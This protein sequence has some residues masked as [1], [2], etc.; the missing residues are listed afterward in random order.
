MRVFVVA[1]HTGNENWNS[2]GVYKDDCLSVAPHTGNENWNNNLPPESGVRKCRSPYGERE[3]KIQGLMMLKEQIMSLPIR[4]AWIETVRTV[5]CTQSK[6]SLSMRGAWIETKDP[7]RYVYPHDCSTCGEREL[8][9]PRYLGA[10][11]TPYR[12]PWG[13]AWIEIA[14]LGTN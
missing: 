7:E 4:G 12:S 13:G 10:A 9:L 14:R 8:K 1:P 2:P 3:L 11:D 5:K 6:W